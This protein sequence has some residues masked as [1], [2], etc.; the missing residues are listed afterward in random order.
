[1]IRIFV[2]TA[3][4]VMP[5]AA[6]ASTS[7]CDRVCLRSILDRYMQAV[8]AHAP[9]DAPLSGA[10]RETE[11]AISVPVGKGVWRSVTGLGPVQRYYLDPVSGQVAYFGIVRENDMLA[12]VTARLR[13]ENR[14]VTEAE[15][16]I[17]RDGDPGLPGAHP[18]NA[19]NPKSLI[20]HPPPERVL[21]PG[22]RLPRARMIAI[23]N[24][25]YDAIVAHD[26]SVALVHPGCERFENGTRVTG[27][28]GDCLSGLKHFNLTYVA[29]RRIPLVDAQAGIVLGMAVFIRRP[30]SIVPRNCF[31]EWFWIDGSK[32]RSIWTAMYYPRPDLPVP[33]WPPYVGNLPLPA[34][35]IPTASDKH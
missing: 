11:N 27:R 35:V 29:A 2:L 23:A 18:P 7:G 13:V 20:A 30:G 25:Y 1:M 24:S 28:H 8:V 10:Y 15:W 21:P 17:A 6:A 16:Y 33:N 3:L 32:I 31:S 34:G 9:S 22:E 26:R 4:S 5:L 12:I 19:W 14:A